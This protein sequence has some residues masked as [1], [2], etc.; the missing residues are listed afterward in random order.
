MCKLT[1][2]RQCME[3]PVI[4]NQPFFFVYPMKGFWIVARPVSLA[5]HAEQCCS[6]DKVTTQT[7]CLSNQVILSSSL[8]AGDWAPERW[9]VPCY[10]IHSQDGTAS[11]GL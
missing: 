11:V 7:D 6:P 9:A 5:L 2:T 4:F 3:L 8:V 10:L 1:H